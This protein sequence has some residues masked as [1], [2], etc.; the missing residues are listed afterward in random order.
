MKHVYLIYVW[1]I[2][3]RLYHAIHAGTLLSKTRGRPVRQSGAAQRKEGNV[4]MSTLNV[5]VAIVS[6]TYGG[7]F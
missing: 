1:A 2:V 6:S 7:V 5:R 3:G 4:K